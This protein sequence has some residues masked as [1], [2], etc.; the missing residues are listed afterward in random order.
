M[1]FVSTFGNK[2]I[3]YECNRFK[4]IYMRIV[5]DGFK[6]E[7]IFERNATLYFDSNKYTRLYG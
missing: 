2:A 4:C 5:P 6:A 1:Q 3:G 7:V